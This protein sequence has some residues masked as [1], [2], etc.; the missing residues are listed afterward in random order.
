MPGV[1]S[2][3][4]LMAP[5]GGGAIGGGLPA[6]ASN[7]GSQLPE[8][9]A[10]EG[11]VEDGDGHA[12]L[13]MV[14]DTSLGPDAFQSSGNVDADDV[15]GTADEG[16]ARTADQNQPRR[17]AR[18]GALHTIWRG[19]AGTDMSELRVCPFEVP[20]GERRRD[21]RILSACRVR[22]AFKQEDRQE[23]A[24][25]NEGAKNARRKF[26]MIYTDMMEGFKDARSFSD[27]IAIENFVLHVDPQGEYAKFIRCVCVL[28][29][30]ARYC[31]VFR[32]LTSWCHGYRRMGDVGKCVVGEHDGEEI[33]EE[34]KFAP[35]MP[36][37]LALFQQLLHSCEAPASSD[38]DFLNERGEVV[39]VRGQGLGYPQV[40]AY[41][42]ACA[43]LHHMLGIADK[44]PTHDESMRV[45]L[46]GMRA[47][48]SIE[49]TSA[50]DMLEDLPFIRAAIFDT[51]N[52]P[53][54]KSEAKKA[55]HWALFL[56]LVEHAHR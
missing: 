12:D 49:H 55:H 2:T 45:W 4:A 17:L 11:D 25:M 42:C 39:K 40:H 43:K 29:V 20:R 56:Y 3:F 34:S 37:P 50:L 19:A 41:W 46:G 10:L 24:H 28:V 6:T 21:S 7:G 26:N 16:I 36:M 23:W 1:I 31:F 15:A 54:S 14:H 32:M 13:Y 35:N 18:I 33:I 38:L 52:Q 51:P 22:Q 44:C 9:A 5:H 27:I 47:R 8:S 53:W 30:G 48:H